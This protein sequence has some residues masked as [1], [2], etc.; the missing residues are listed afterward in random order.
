VQLRIVVHC[1]LLPCAALPVMLKMELQRLSQ[2]FTVSYLHFSLELHL[3]GFGS[4]TGS[5]MSFIAQLGYNCKSPFIMC[6]MHDHDRGLLNC[7]SSGR[8]V[9]ALKNRTKR[10]KACLLG[11]EELVRL[12]LKWST[13][14]LLLPVVLYICSQCCVMDVMM[15]FI[16]LC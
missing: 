13:M 16:R 8:L 2:T 1:L 7:L 15:F 11:F 4:K 5:V 9:L 6:V 3:T 10:F 14:Q 12:V